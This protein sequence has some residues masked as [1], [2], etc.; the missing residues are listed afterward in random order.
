MLV[1][2]FVGGV[3]GVGGVVVIDVGVGFV[4][5]VVVGGVIGRVCWLV[6]LCLLVV[7]LFLCVV[8]GFGG[9]GDFVGWDVCVFCVWLGVLVWCFFSGCGGVVGV[10]RCR[11][12]CMFCLGG[13]SD[14]DVVI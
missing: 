10:S 14:G 13:G 3:L 1:W 2:K 8:V 4:L 11:L 5:V 6:L 9:G 7:I 12:M